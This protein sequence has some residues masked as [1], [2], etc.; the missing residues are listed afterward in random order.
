MTTEERAR[1]AIEALHRSSEPN[2]HGFLVH[3]ISSL[4]AL[5]T[6]IPI[7]SPLIL[8]LLAYETWV[9][10]T[11]WSWFAPWALPFT[12]WQGVGMNLAASLIFRQAI[13]TKDERASKEKFN[14]AFSYAVA[15]PTASL[16]LAWILRW[17][18]GA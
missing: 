14:D 10:M 17:W 2:A 12:L 7:A 1:R 6:V 18:I 5:P 13:H 8:G 4:I 11:I 3:V 16:I 9:A 15:G